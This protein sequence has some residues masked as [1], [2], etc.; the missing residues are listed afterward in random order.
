[1]VFVA[2]ECLYLPAASE[3]ML[4][5]LEI[6]PLELLAYYIAVRRGLDPDR[7]RNLNKAVTVSGEL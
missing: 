3:L 7:P 6:V 1:M 4:P 5:L 2:D